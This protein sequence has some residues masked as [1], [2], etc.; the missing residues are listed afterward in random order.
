MNG[1]AVKIIGVVASVLGAAATLAGNWATAKETDEKI[2]T[3]VAE[4][5]AEAV[6][7][8]GDA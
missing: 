3:R 1:K 4:A 6:S 2:A 5:V 8:K 7:N